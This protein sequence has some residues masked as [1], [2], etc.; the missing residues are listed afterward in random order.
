MMASETKPMPQDDE[1]VMPDDLRLCLDGRAFAHR[2]A[3]RIGHAY[4]G[5][6]M[7]TVKWL[8]G[9]ILKIERDAQQRD[10]RRGAGLERE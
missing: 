3:D 5:G 8:H 6:D 9:R 10:A 1:Q 4:K 7:G 2:I